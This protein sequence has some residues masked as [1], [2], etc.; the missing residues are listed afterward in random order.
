MSNIISVISGRTKLC[1]FNTFHSNR[2]RKY[3]NFLSN[4]P[5]IQIPEI[6]ETSINAFP[7]FVAYLLLFLFCWFFF[8]VFANPPS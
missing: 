2:I 7:C 3:E 6:G 4:I 8:S 1:L 5:V